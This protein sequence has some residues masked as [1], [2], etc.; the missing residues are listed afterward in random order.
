MSHEEPT[1]NN[2]D[3]VV[4]EFKPLPDRSPEDQVK[5]LTQIVHQMSQNCFEVRLEMNDLREQN[6]ALKAEL[7]YLRGI[8]DAQAQKNYLNLFKN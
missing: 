1:A 2:D 8:T 6:I 4:H 5:A 7:V 3:V